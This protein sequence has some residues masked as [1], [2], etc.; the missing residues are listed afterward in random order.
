MASPTVPD[1]FLPILT[2]KKAFAHLATTMP[3]GSPQVTPVW[4]LYK[5]GKFIVNTARGRVK[6]RNMS[7]NS[8]VA[9]S[10][11]DPDNPYSHIAVRGKVVR[12]TEDGADASIDALAQKYL[13]KDKY[14]LRRPGEVRVIYEIEPT[15]VSAMG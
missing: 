13:G 11:L 10:V 4:F 8:R 6:D 15:S 12:V 9:L 14:P 7:Q 1:K 2:Q 3:D 5:D